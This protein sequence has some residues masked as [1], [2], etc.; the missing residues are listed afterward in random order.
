MGCAMSHLLDEEPTADGSK[1]G[2]FDRSMV[3][4]AFDSPI[5]YVAVLHQLLDGGMTGLGTPAQRVYLQ[6]VRE[7][8][9][10]QRPTVRMTHEP[11][12]DARKLLHQH[13]ERG[14]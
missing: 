6:L 5:H 7:S 12:T 2:E 9:A 4:A 14:A 11:A 10:R 3:R 13:G 8:L 1:R